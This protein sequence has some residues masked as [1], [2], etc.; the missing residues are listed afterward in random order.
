[1]MKRTNFEY[2]SMINKQSCVH[3]QKL[4]LYKKNHELLQKC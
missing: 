1:M 4:D 2:L 3:Y